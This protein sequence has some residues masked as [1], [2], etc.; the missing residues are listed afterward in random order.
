MKRAELFWVKGQI[1]PLIPSTFCDGEVTNSQGEALSLEVRSAHPQAWVDGFHTESRGNQPLAGAA[2]LSLRTCSPA[3]PVL[4]TANS[5]GI[6]RTCR[7]GA[8][9][10]PAAVRGLNPRVCSEGVEG[11]GWSCLDESGSTRLKRHLRSGRPLDL[12]QGLWKGPLGMSLGLCQPI[13]SH[14]GSL[15]SLA[16]LLLKYMGWWVRW[17]PFSWQKQPGSG[18]DWGQEVSV[19]Q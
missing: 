10:G 4:G 3:R 15:F 11:S 18:E 19:M 9:E 6:T 1:F 8:S 2:L 13:L 16:S 12:L 14:K 17:G 7:Q 5:A